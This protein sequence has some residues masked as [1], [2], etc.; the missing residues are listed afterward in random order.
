M[1]RLSTAALAACL[2]AAVVVPTVAAGKPDR[3]VIDQ[4]D[5]TPI[6]DEIVDGACGVD[7]ETSVR[8]HVIISIW[9]DAEG[10]VIDEIDRFSTRFW[11]RNPATGEIYRFSDAG[12][13]MYEFDYEAGTITYSIIGRSAT[14]SAVAGRVVLLLDLETG[15]QIGDP[16]FVAGHELGDWVENVCGALA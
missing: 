9:S 11:F 1:R 4:A 3:I 2:L 12:P 5:F 16:V 14:G 10:N 7:L 13:D 6:I 15:E 8:G